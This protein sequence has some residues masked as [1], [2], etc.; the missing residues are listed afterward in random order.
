MAHI[1]KMHPSANWLRVPDHIY[2][3]ALG[4][5]IELGRPDEVHF[6]GCELPALLQNPQYRQQVEARVAELQGKSDAIQ[7]QVQCQVGS[8]LEE[9]GMLDLERHRL[10]ELLA[11]PMPVEV[12]SG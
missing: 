8:L 4:R 11:D 1:A 2:R 6:W 5:N 3:Q 10:A 12:I 7:Q 9:Q